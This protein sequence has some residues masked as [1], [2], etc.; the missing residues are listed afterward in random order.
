VP[1]WN[2]NAFGRHMYIGMAGYK[3][4]DATQNA[5]FATD[6]NQIPNQLRLNRQ[7]TNVNGHIFYNT[8]SLRNNNLG[9]RDSLRLNFFNK[10]ALQPTMIWKDNVAPLPATLLNAVSSGV[11]SITLN[12]TKPADVTNEL[13]KVKRFAIYRSNNPTVDISNANNLLAITWNDTTAFTD[14]TAVQGS[15][16]YYV[17]TALDRLQNESSVSN[18][19]S[20]VTT[21]IALLPGQNKNFII[22]P[23]IISNG[24]TINIKRNNLLSEKTTFIIFDALGRIMQQGKIDH[25]NTTIQLNPRINNGAYFLKLITSNGLSQQQSIIVL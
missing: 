17:V 25:L 16:Y 20:V 8:T 9:F 23:T 3:V 6:N 14:L 4:G 12:W 10:P 5:A 19:A 18:T 13:N 15:N 7:N 21:S 1:W 24:A 2:N 11:N 22:Y